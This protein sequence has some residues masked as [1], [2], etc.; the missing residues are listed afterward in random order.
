MNR[1]A[2]LLLL[3][4]TVQ[5]EPRHAKWSPRQAAQADSP[6]PLNSTNYFWNAKQGQWFVP[7]PTKT[8]PSKAGLAKASRIIEARQKRGARLREELANL[9]RARAMGL[10]D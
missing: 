6:K 5:A 9:Q 10:M 4:L 3:C 7:G 1:A 8:A 2:L